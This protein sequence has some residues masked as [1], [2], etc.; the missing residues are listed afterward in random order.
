LNRWR[1]NGHSGRI[2]MMVL[3]LASFLAG[4]HV[5]STSGNLDD[6]AF[7]AIKEPVGVAATPGR[8]LVTHPFCGDP[9]QVLSIEST[10]AVRVFA[11]LPPRGGGCFE[12]YIAIAGPADP[13]RPG[14]PSPTR[15]GFVSNQIFVTQGTKIKKIAH[16]GSSVTLFTTI[17]TCGNSHN[18]ITFDH[19]GSFGFAMIVTCA[20][21]GQVWKVTSAGAKTLIATIPDFIENP[22]VAPLGFTPFGGHVLVAAES[23]NK[24]WAV[25]SSGAVSRVANWPGAEGVNAIPASKC[26]FATTGGA[27]FTAISP[28]H[29]AKFALGAFAGLSGRV[30]VTSENNGG[31]GLL[32]ST[33]SGV[34]VTS[35]RSN[36]GKHEGSAFVDC[37]VPLLLKI[38]VDRSRDA[39]HPETSESKERIA[40]A[41]LSS[42][43]FDAVAQ[44]IVPSIRFGV[45]GTEKS[46]KSC[47]K[48]G[49]DVNGDGRKD[50]VCQAEIGKLGLRDHKVQNVP[51]ILK[52]KYNAPEGDPDGEGRD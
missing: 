33:G 17:P 23:T 34:T 47:E 50:L 32:T 49:F 38:I 29:V 30:L 9:R 15:G 48:R 46:I 5:G 43:I 19:E 16:D 45:T 37:A 8:L 1:R 21:S 18:G 39:R 31:I 11:T 10:G 7:A 3:V 14:F 44:T 13:T 52:L 4:P 26:T 20:Q 28:K 2:G 42:P 51:L 40:V 22:T 25:S 41:I 12:E 6:V 36:I 24:V 27:F 35:F